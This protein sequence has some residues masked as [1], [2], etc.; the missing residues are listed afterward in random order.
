MESQQSPRSP[1]PVSDD[2]RAADSLS[3][4]PHITAEAQ[5]NATDPASRNRSGRDG[6]GEK[7]NGT[8]QHSRH[9]RRRSKSSRE[10]VRLNRSVRNLKIILTTVI[11]MFSAGAVVGK[12]YH[13]KL[14]FE[15]KRLQR[16]VDRLKQRAEAAES[17]NKD[18]L[19]DMNEMVESRLPG[20]RKIVFDQVIKISERYVKNLIF[21]VSKDQS[22]T[23]YEYRLVLFNANSTPVTARVKLRLFNNRGIEVGNTDATETGA[24]NDGLKRS[25]APG[26]IRSY[27]GS[28]A[29]PKGT[30][31]SYFLLDIG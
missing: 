20:L 10:A 31:P 25:L 17:Q 24:S 8:G 11:M 6:Q 4:N 13:D 2:A 29:V 28:I 5:T 19:T 27:S 23:S 3:D 30:P 21:L 18:L 7:S 16:S 14:V 22:R 15:N 26:E 12:K 9:R 1:S